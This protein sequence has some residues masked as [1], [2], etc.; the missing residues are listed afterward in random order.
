V[1]NI[2]AEFSKFTPLNK[3][4]NLPWIA[5][6]I[7][8][9]CSV[10]NEVAATIHRFGR[11]GKPADAAAV[12]RFSEFA[13]AF[14]RKLTPALRSDVKDFDQW[15]AGTN[16]TGGR[17][18]SLR[19]VREN[20][21]ILNH[22]SSVTGSFLKYEGYQKP[23][24]PRAINAFSDEVKV[25]VAPIGEAADKATFRH[26]NFVK[27]MDASE[28][29][30]LMAELFGHSP[31]VETDFTSFESHHRGE[32]AE[33]IFYWM[34][35]MT[36]GMNLPT[37]VRRLFA[38]CIKG[39]NKCKFGLTRCSVD[40]TLMSGAAWTSSSNGV[41]NLLIMSYLW[42]DQFGLPVGEQADYAFN[43]FTGLIEGD[44]GICPA[45]PVNYALI[46]SLGIDLKLEVK[47][48]YGLASFCGIVCPPNSRDILYSPERLFRNF[49][50]IPAKLKDRKQSVKDAYIRAK[51]LSYR[52]SFGNAPVVGPIVR[53][54]CKLTKSINV[55]NV[56]TH[57]DVY[58][59]DKIEIALKTKSHE[60]SNPI[61]DSLRDHCS[62]VFGISVERQRE[63]EEGFEK[64]L[65]SDVDLS[66][67]MMPF[68]DEHTL[69]HVTRE[70]WPEIP[71]Q[72]HHLDEKI[73]NVIRNGGLQRQKRR[74]ANNRCDGLFGSNVWSI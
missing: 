20:P 62:Q 15:L 43:K 47:P 31:V 12:S 3:A 58:Q 42:S 60:K 44:D 41:L 67:W 68:D 74:V 49:F 9:P 50:V 11:A 39:R 65:C 5:P 7:P 70:K 29:P 71:N 38:A 34:M 4:N 33:I 54:V 24:N 21:I 40:Q 16:Y 1:N 14:I 28:R 53:H 17:K 6:L 8:N 61:S 59:R 63:M 35:H 19:K 45:F 56:L 46:E 10:K 18:A 57:F 72:G 26:R 23:K 37:H 22:K 55:E 66:S 30:E 48:Y 52:H 13:K 27:G 69:M 25:I 73:K 2:V 64:N 36:R 32:F 51:A